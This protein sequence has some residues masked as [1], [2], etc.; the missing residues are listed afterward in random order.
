MLLYDTY[1]FSFC[2]G[3]G[4]LFSITGILASI[5][6]GLLFGP[7]RMDY[8]VVGMNFTMTVTCLIAQS[9]PIS[10][11]L[12]ILLAVLAS[13][14]ATFFSTYP[15][16]QCYNMMNKNVKKIGHIG[17]PLVFI[18]N[19]VYSFAVKGYISNL[20]GA[21]VFLSASPF[22]FIFGIYQ[23]QMILR[24]IKQHP[25]S[26]SDVNYT[27]QKRLMLI[28]RYTVLGIIIVVAPAMGVAMYGS[29]AEN[30]SIWSMC[31]FF[32]ILLGFILT[33]S[34]FFM[35]LNKYIK[36][37]E[38]ARRNSVYCIASSIVSEFPRQTNIK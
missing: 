5:C 24:V 38:A 11:I 17:Y 32:Q 9:V 12:W 2:Y 19:L 20:I 25:L 15:Y 3:F 26:I 30:A 33:I 35:T 21:I 13:F 14:Y 23:F 22:M 10:D 6:C 8:F 34:N 31:I 27:K 37:V 28:T 7:S 18:A 29:F 1:I 36:Y 16:F 4:L